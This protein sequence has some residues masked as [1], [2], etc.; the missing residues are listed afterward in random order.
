M[1]ISSNFGEKKGL[2]NLFMIR[3]LKCLLCLLWFFDTVFSFTDLY[4]KDT[5]RS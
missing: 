4:F 1:K 2:M 5:L 3:Y